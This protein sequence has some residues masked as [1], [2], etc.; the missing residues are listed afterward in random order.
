MT[1]TKPAQNGTNIRTS[2]TVWIL[3]LHQNLKQKVKSNLDNFHKAIEI[4]RQILNMVILGIYK[5][6]AEIFQWNLCVHFVAV[7]EHDMKVLGHT[8]PA[9]INDYYFS[10][11]RQH[12]FP[13]FK[14]NYY[15][16]GWHTHKQVPFDDV[17]WDFKHA[18]LKSKLCRFNNKFQKQNTTVL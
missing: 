13:L 10:I 12:I 14:N 6:L 9:F 17:V 15:F 3:S 18:C 16:W 8:L 5:S 11:F 2:G 1:L 4:D 7:S